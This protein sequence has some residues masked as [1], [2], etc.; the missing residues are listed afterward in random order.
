MFGIGMNEFLLILLL[1]VVLIG[2]KQLPEVARGLAKVLAAFRRAT[3]DLRSAVSEEINSRPEYRELSKLRDEISG[4]VNKLTDRARSF[5]EKEFQDEQ[6]I[7]GS[8]ERDVRKMGENFGKTVEA[9]KDISGPPAAGA[10]GEGGGMPAGGHVAATS[11]APWNVQYNKFYN[12]SVPAEGAAPAAP[13]NGP[14]AEAASKPSA[15][16]PEA[17]SAEATSAT[18]QSLTPQSPVAQSPEDLYL[19]ERERGST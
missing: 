10:A 15:Q 1:A 12:T 5:M 7:A 17:Q 18:A 4:D 2:P 9:G 13:G 11:H 16:S 14:G 6:R 19:K 3:A 8:V